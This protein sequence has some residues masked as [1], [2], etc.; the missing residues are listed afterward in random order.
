MTT[1]FFATVAIVGFAAWGL[2]NRH[3][4]KSVSAHAFSTLVNIIGT[5]LFIPVALTNLSHSNTRM[6]WLA[7]AIASAV[8]ATYSI[9]SSISTKNT[10]ASVR[11]PLSQSKLLWTVLLGALV[12]REVVTWQ[13]VAAVFVIFI[14]IS[15]LLW[16][17]E[18]KF[19]SLKDPGVRWTLI[20][21]I[22]SA[23]A[24]IADKYAL[25]FFS[26]ELYGF[27]A[28]FF[29][30][31]ILLAFTPHQGNDIKHLLKTSKIKIFVASVIGAASYYA[32]LKVYSALEISVAYPLLQ[33]STLLI[34][35]GGILFFKEKGNLWQKIIATIIVIAGSVWLKLG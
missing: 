24:A 5:I 8:W 1:F 12:L 23:F 18:R 32:T 10:E 26:V 7:I 15:T 3:I 19:G 4:L 34:V 20:A 35:F 2:F 30:A 22:F 33:L 25:G 16:H 21:A 13:H 27:L 29:P 14:G 9:L 11:A 28:Y 6:A 17:P 31:L